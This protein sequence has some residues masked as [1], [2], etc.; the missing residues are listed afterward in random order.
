MDPSIT[1]SNSHDSPHA[2]LT[3][4]I[5]KRSKIITNLHLVLSLR[6]LHSNSISR[7]RRMI[8]IR[9]RGRGRGHLG[10]RY[11]LSLNPSALCQIHRE[12][13][14]A[15]TKNLSNKRCTMGAN[16]SNRKCNSKCSLMTILNSNRLIWT[17]ATLAQTTWTRSASTSTCLEP[18]RVWVAVQARKQ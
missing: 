6:Q 14:E 3:S 5:S 9:G 12:G 10:S 17:S 11:S 4:L 13:R 18:S 1:R 16:P 2:T 7:W 8:T 15:R